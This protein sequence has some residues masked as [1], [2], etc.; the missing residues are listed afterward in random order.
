MGCIGSWVMRNL[1]AE[2]VNVVA[3]DIALEPARPRL[4]M[5]EEELNRVNF[6]KMDVTDLENVK[7]VVE[8]QR[9]THIVHLAGLQVPFCKGE[10]V[11]GRTGQRG[12]HGEH[13]RGG[14]RVPG[15]RC[16][17]LR[18]RVRWPCWD[19]T[20]S[21]RTSRSWTARRSIHRRCMACTSRQMRARRGCTGRTGRSPVWGCDPTSCMAW[22]AT[23]A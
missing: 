11:A 21:I 12:G 9:V 19:R 17:A 13:L 18:T 16:R 23:R 3:T 20:N 2:G 1:V 7:S 15:A 10:S 22:R 8:T 4:L 5:S 6:V 14:A